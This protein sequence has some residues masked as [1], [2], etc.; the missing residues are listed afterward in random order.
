LLSVSSI[1]GFIQVVKADSGTIYIRADGSIDPPTAPIYTAENITYTLTGN[2]TADASMGIVIERGNIVVDG[3]LYTVQGTGV[4]ES[5]GIYLS[6]IVNGMTNVTIRNMT[7]KAFSY[8]IWLVYSPFCTIDRSI[9]RMKRL[10]ENQ[11]SQADTQ[12]TPS[13]CHLD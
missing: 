5:R 12:P 1:T 8:G 7:I 4:G 13:C 3:A 11:Y 9:K 2:I 6:G 10:W